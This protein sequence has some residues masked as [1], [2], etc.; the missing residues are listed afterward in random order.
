MAEIAIE[1]AAGNRLRSEAETA[2]R[3]I[4]AYLGDRPDVDAVTLSPSAD[5]VFCVS[6]EGDRIW[7]TDPR[8]WIDAM[9]AV[10]AARR[11]LSE[12]S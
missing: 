9:E 4:N 8:E 12:V 11:R 5:S 1:Y 3:L 7:C 6:V 2:R 10:T